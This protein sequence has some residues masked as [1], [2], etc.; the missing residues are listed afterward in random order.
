[1]E[2]IRDW[3]RRYFN[4]PQVVVLAAVLVVGLAIVLA[5]G[6][7]LTPVIASLILA[8]LLESLVRGFERMLMPRL[9]AVWVVFTAFMTALLFVFFALIPLLSRQLTQL[10][11]LLPGMLAQGQDLLLTLP[12]RYPNLFTEEQVAEYTSAVR[13][14]VGLFAQRLLSV[15]LASVLGLVTLIVYVIIMPLLVFFFLKDK[16]AILNWAS[17][18]LPRRRALVTQVWRDVNSQIGNYIRGKFIEILI[19]WMVTYVTFAI[20]GLQ[21]ALLV[22]L[23]VGLSVLIPY[24]GAAVAT[25][26]VA[27]IGFF[28]WGLST[29]FTYLM[30]AYAII[31][32]LDGNV[33]VP[34]LFSEVVNLHPIAIIVAVFVFGGLWGFWGVFFAIP[35]ATLVQAVLDAWPRQMPTEEATGET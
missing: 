10:I 9:L 28:Q 27:L 25:I 34:I 35:L 33:L 22:G 23:V 2:L 4:D 14:E 15:S 16:H 31:Q 17:Q 29:E 11:Q 19:V 13:T 12:E 6:K 1:V 21:F 8:Y 30:I 32:T 3:F 24:I 20:L 5:L 7:W 18:F 26:P